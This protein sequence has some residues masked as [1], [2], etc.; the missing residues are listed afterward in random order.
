[1]N[2]LA[3]GL[4]HG[5]VDS[6]L[7]RLTRLIEDE[8][9][10]LRGVHSDIQYIKDEMESV[11]GFLLN[12]VEGDCTDRQMEVWTKQVREVARESQNC[13]DI[14]VHKLGPGASILDRSVIFNHFWSMRLDVSGPI[15]RSLPAQHRLATKIKELKV[16]AQEVSERWVR[17]GI[18]DPTTQVRRENQLQEV[19][20]DT[21]GKE[22]P[23]SLHL[24]GED[25]CPAEILEGDT[26]MLVSWLIE[27]GEDIQLDMLVAKRLTGPE[28]EMPLQE[29]PV[30][31]WTKKKPDS[32]SGRSRRRRM[33]RRPGLATASS[34]RWMLRSRSVKS[35]QLEDNIPL[36][37]FQL[38]CITGSRDEMPRQDKQLLCLT[39]PRKKES[40]PRVISIVQQPSG[41]DNLNLARKVYEDSLIKQY[42]GFRCWVRVGETHAKWVLEDIIKAVSS[43]QM[44]LKEW[45][46]TRYLIVLDDVRDESLC[47]RII[48]TFPPTA[49]GA[50]SV[51]LVI[52]HSY[53][54]ARS[55]SPN[56]VFPPLEPLVNFFFD[57]AVSLVENNPKNDILKPVIW[58]ILSKCVPDLLCLKAFLHVLYVNP[59]SNIEELQS[60][61]NDLTSDSPDNI[62]HTLMFWYNSLPLH[63]KNCL[64]YLSIFPQNDGDHI[65]RTSLVRRWAA[66]NLIIGRNGSTAQDEAE[67]CFDVLLAKRFI[68]RRDISAAGKV[69]SCKVN[70][71][72]SKFISDIAREE[73][74]VDADLEPDFGRRISIHDRRQL[75]QVLGTVHASPRPSSCWNIRKHS[76]NS[77]D[78]QTLDD[79][80][81]FL[82]TLPSFAGLGLLRVLDLEDFD[83][84]KDHHVDNICEIFQLRYLNLRRT[85]ITKLPKKIEYLQQLETLD[86]RET[87]VTSFATKAVVLPMLKNMLAGCTQHP[88]EDIES[89]STVC[90][91]RGIDKAT[92]LQI[93]CHVDVSGKE[94]R[95][96]EIGKLL[97]LRKLGVVLQSNGENFKH[98]LQAIERLNQSLRSL[99][100]RVERT[101]DHEIIDINAAEPIAFSPPKHLQSLNLCGIRG[102]L[103][104]W[105]RELHKL[106]KLTLCDTHLGEEDMVPLGELSGLR[107]LR[108]RHKSYVQTK[109]TLEEGA[110]KNLE[111]ILI[112]GADITDIS[113]HVTPKIEKI[114]WNFREMKSIHGVSR[115]PRLK[116]LEL[117]GNCDPTAIKEALSG[118]PNGPAVTHNGQEI[119]GAGED[120]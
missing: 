33:K 69:K 27:Q 56:K 13:V 10:L 71:L 48:S 91:P 93:L 63:Y 62:R 36:H 41:D 76:T 30:E 52:T 11:Y 114:V 1:M 70:G 14:Y 86:I 32:G 37:G 18:R 16:R 118:H 103:P 40:Y 73:K 49:A 89:F 61:C 50:H 53:A 38:E 45:Q 80:T 4:A 96:T 44:D 81:K 47:R 84:L 68:L 23:R 83:G 12:S 109:L 39:K 21:N 119:N 87:A 55:F 98:L 92:N 17:Y 22:D 2:D 100:L 97:Q 65:R 77:E 104:R 66:E 115:L 111:F 74:F 82:E 58:S 106:A 78:G 35:A 90:M 26:K 120:E 19:G 42:F 59:M 113:F 3:I 112:E 5:A 57:K 116:R 20:E 31:K 79:L 105:I 51:V 95:L 94:D 107:C 7:G 117:I 6:L 25:E 75:Q 60:L 15:V 110:F 108:L 72:I 34:K 8:A 9:R 43:Q 46:E 64:I 101:D 102:G 85:K 54:L 28:D 88:N 24:L 29:I 67:H 99:S